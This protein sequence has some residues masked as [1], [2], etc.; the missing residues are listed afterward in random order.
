ML[1][2][3]LY[4]GLR[5]TEL[6]TLRMKDYTDR[7]GVKTLVVHGKGSKIRY[8]PVHPK[9]V[10]A[11]ND[12]LE[13]SQIAGDDTAPLFIPSPERSARGKPMLRQ[14]VRELVQRY[15]KGLELPKGSA[16]PHALRATA[17]TNALEHGADFA[18]VQHWL[19]HAN[20]ATTELYDKW[21]DRPE[22]S[23]TFR[24]MY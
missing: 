24:V 16:R 21:K 6:C 20:P 14:R 19:G 7:R 12:Y 2:V 13:V 11:M 3:L 23:P 22:E 5:A 15:A 8:L 17:A 18:K 4:H 9:A 10:A 1:A